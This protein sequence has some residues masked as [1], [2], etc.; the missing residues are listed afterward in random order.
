MVA[1]LSV[2]LC[3]NIPLLICFPLL[4]PKQEGAQCKCNLGR[5]QRRRNLLRQY[6]DNNNLELQAIFAVQALFVQLE[7]PPGTNVQSCCFCTIFSRIS[8]YFN[9]VRDVIE[10]RVRE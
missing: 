3:E 8:I 9:L 1:G 7:H 5:L 4:S 2:L 10:I 6:I